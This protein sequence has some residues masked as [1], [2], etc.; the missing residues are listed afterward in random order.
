MLS[1]AFVFSLELRAVLRGSQ[2]SV[3]NGD[4]EPPPQANSVL[5]LVLSNF[6]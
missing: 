6:S 4:L 2:I 5:H 1:K 3:T